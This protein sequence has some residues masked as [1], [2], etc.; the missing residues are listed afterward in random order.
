MDDQLIDRIAD[1]SFDPLTLSHEELEGGIHRLT[2]ACLATPL[3]C[4]SSLQNV[5]VQ[6]LMSAIL[7]YLP[8]PEERRIAV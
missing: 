7:S 6:P 3:L 1:D 8:G 5:A 2:K 4:G